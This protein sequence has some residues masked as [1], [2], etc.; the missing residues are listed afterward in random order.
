METQWSAKKKRTDAFRR[1][2]I[3]SFTQTIGIESELCEIFF[4]LKYGLSQCR[5][6]EH[7]LYDSVEHVAYLLEYLFSILKK[8]MFRSEFRTIFGF[9]HRL[10]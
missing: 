3:Y 9:A 6:D 2:F 7:V 5:F 8:K 1:N 10:N 4:Q